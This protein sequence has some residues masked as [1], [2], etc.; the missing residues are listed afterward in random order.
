MVN[1]HSCRI[2]GS[3]S[4]HGVRECERDGPKLNVWC[5]LSRHEVTGF[6]FFQEKTVDNTD[7]LECLRYLQS[8]KWYTFNKTF[9]LNKMAPLHIR[10]LPVRESLNK[11]FPNWW[12]RRDRPIPCPPRS[13][14]I[15][16]LDFLFCRCVKDQVFRPKVG[17][18]VNFAHESTMQLLLWHPR[19]GKAHGV[20]SSAVWT[21]CELQMALTLRCIELDELFFQVKQTNSLCLVYSL[22]CVY[23][24]CGE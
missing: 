21:F 5:A 19:R 2:W 1:R 23:L 9:S 24:K 13:H 10:A 18:V 16:L 8:R 15:T 7:Y 6:F 12:I 11:T 4:P 3:E 20:T 17:S 22:F 14:D